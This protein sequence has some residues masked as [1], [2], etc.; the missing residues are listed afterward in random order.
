MSNKI[1]R[2]D[3]WAVLPQR[4]LARGKSR[5][6]GVLD[7]AARHE[8]NRWL[9]ERTLGVVAHWLGDTRRCVVVSPDAATLATAHAYGATASRDAG[10]GLNAAVGQGAAYAAARGA[11][12]WLILPCD[13][14]LL[15][16]A[17]LS[18]MAVRKTA[19]TAVIAPDRHGTGTN[20]LLVNAVERIF[21]FGANSVKRHT[22]DF[23]ARGEQVCLYHRPELAFDLDTA[24]DLAHWLRSGYDLP[25]I[26]ARH[27]QP[28]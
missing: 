14:P 3:I 28:A 13:L 17:A 1:N 25:P 7:A 24:E 27:N 11:R 19:G 20:G 26:L 21:A 6:A 12:K 2:S 10:A 15:D 4:G 23:A 18:A 22:A 8:L 5:L 9:L 16:R